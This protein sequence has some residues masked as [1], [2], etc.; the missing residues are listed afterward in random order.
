MR[1]FDE[2]KYWDIYWNGRQS[3]RL[4]FIESE[5]R[6]NVRE[7]LERVRPDDQGTFRDS[8]REKIDE[9]LKKLE[10]KP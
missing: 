5:I 8:M 10:A 3:E 7:A 9:E 6:R 1:L 2:K 4:D